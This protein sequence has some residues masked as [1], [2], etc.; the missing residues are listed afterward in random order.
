MTKKT[1]YDKRN[2]ELKRSIVSGAVFSVL[3]AVILALVIA[4]G[5]FLIR[6]EVFKTSMYPTLDNKDIVYANKY[7]KP[8][9][10]DI[11]IISGEESEWII[12][13]VIGK[14]GDIVKIEGGYVYLKKSGEEAFNK[15]EEKYLAVQGKTPCRLGANLEESKIFYVGEKEIFY[16][17]DNRTVSV[18]SR[19]SFGNCNTEQI[20]GVVPKWAVRHKDFNTAVYRVIVK[21]SQGITQLFGGKS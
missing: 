13:R 6:I 12:K 10:G 5:F 20:V 16:L 19:S 2:S 21:I 18:D 17:G 3:L 9:Y 14:E 4:N 8:D 7:R 1:L 15:L 11:V